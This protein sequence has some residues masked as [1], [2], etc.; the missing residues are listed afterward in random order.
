[1]KTILEGGRLLLIISRA[2][3]FKAVFFRPS[4]LLKCIML[5][6]L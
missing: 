5:K 1:M 6:I 3:L 2:D 4:Y